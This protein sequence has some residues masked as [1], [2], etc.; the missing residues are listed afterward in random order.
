MKEDGIAEAMLLAWGLWNRGGKGQGKLPSVSILGRLI[1]EGAGASHSTVVTEP[2]MSPTVELVER[3]VL[4]KL[5]KQLR[6]IAKRRFIGDEPDT[7]AARKEKLTLREY[8]EKVNQVV[9]ALTNY[10]IEN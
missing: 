6:R 4:M 8:E 7:S 2:Y 1:I 3:F 5:S 9:H 10:L